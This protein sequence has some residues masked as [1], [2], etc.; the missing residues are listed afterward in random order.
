MDVPHPEPAPA[1]LSRRSLVK[2]GLLG[3]ALLAAGGAGFLA[4]RSGATVALPGDGLLLFTPAQFAVLD[5]VARRMVRPRQGWPGVDQVGVARAANRIAARV[6]PSAQKEL[7]QLLGLFE[8]GLAGFIFGG[9]TRPFTRLDGAEQDAVL[10]RVA[11]QPDRGAAH[12]LRRA[13]DPGARGLL[14]VARRLA[15]GGLRR[16]APDLRGWALAPRVA[17]GR[18]S[19]VP[20]AT[21]CGTGSRCHEH[22]RARSSPDATTGERHPPLRRGAWWARAPGGSVLAERLTAR[23]LDVVMLEEGG[24]WT[25]RSSTGEEDHSYPRL[26]QEMGNRATDDQSMLILQGRNVG[27]GTTVNWCTSF[28]TPRARAGAL[29]GPSRGAGPVGGG[30]GPPLGGGR[31]TAAHRRVAAGADERQQPGALGRLREARLLAWADPAQREQLRQP[32]LLRPGL[33][34]RRQACRWG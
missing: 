19:R 5:A 14:P 20:T 24:Y 6:E 25:R 12:R 34:A 1:G 11:R 31:E 8:N 13:P 26:Y 29:A 33:P 10:A 7:Q 27:G 15:I 16:P 22:R 17:R 28:R 4:L 21:A 18:T 3:G 32:R 23:G 9:R 30:P 2:R